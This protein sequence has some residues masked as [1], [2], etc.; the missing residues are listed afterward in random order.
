MNLR[1]K[2]TL[3]AL[4][5]SCSLLVPKAGAIGVNDAISQFD[6]NVRNYNLISF[7][8]TILAQSQDTEG[9][10]AVGGDLWI[11]GGGTTPL[12]N[13]YG[14]GSADP[15]VYVKGQLRL[16]AGSILQS[17]N[18][19][20]SLPNQ[21]GSS[22]NAADR[23]LYTDP[24]HSAWVQA[25]NT[26]NPVMNPAPANWDFNTLSQS[27]SEISDTL[28]N[29]SATG[30]FLLNGQTLSLTGAA[31]GVSIFN[32]DLASFNWSGVSL[33]SLT[34]PSEAVFVI[35][36]RNAQGAS[37]FA[38]LNTNATG[39]SAER[40]LWNFVGAGNV[41]LNNNGE[42]FGSVLAEDWNLTL[43]NKEIRGQVVAGSFDREASSE[44][45]FSRFTPPDLPPDK[46]P[47][48]ADTLAV[49]AASLGA[50]GFLRRRRTA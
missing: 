28:G 47:D 32:L 3:L 22:W 29:A 50:L 35:N 30:N 8:D 25:S 26:V 6:A 1:H 48:T 15:A 49:L 10:L 21:V 36:V 46:V 18:G 12:A 2:L 23:R 43:V 34:V 39:T 33:L 38:N 40:V 7:G 42:V 24:S 4:C 19:S 5:G 27:F 31:S 11:K 16:N 13:N 44:L 37:L 14:T 9:T 45:H 41:T 17:N 20:I